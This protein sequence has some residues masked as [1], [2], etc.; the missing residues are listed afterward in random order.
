MIGIIVPGISRL[1]YDASVE[2]GFFPS[3]IESTCDP[4]CA[5]WLERVLHMI[6][7]SPRPPGYGPLGIKNVD[8]DGI[9]RLGRSGKDCYAAILGQDVAALG[10]SMNECSRCWEILLP[11]TLE[12]STISIDL[13]ALLSIYQF[14]YDGAM[15][16][17]CGGGYL[18]VASEE[19]VP[20]SFRFSVRTD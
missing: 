20:G 15:Y 2:G 8:P 19:E 10:R 16:S 9:R 17:G 3:H 11:H 6:P 7:V 18:V 13:R 4:A 5:R 14:R 12:H 1:D